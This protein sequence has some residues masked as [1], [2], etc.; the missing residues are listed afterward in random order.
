MQ[1]SISV[2]QT[3]QL[4]LEQEIRLLYGET[5]GDIPVYSLHRIKN[6]IEK[7]GIGVHK[8]LEL[9]LI[10]NLI[11][12]NSNYRRESGNDWA[13][14]TSNNLTAA[15]E[16]TEEYLEEV[17]QKAADLPKGLR[18][19]VRNLFDQAKKKNLNLIKNW[20]YDNYDQILYDMERKIPWP[21]LK[22]LRKDLAI[23]IAGKIDPFGMDI[24]HM[25]IETACSEGISA[26]NSE[27][28]WEA[29]GGTLF[30]K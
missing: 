23:W 3:Q 24:E 22:R 4:D 20:F 28:A 6:L 2:Q 14:L 5:S 10:R 13:C 27:R 25:V 8:E 21:V 17:V 7:K 1:I 29:M 15:I 9:A 26:T 30:K 12:E 18:D 16:K 19:K 11:A